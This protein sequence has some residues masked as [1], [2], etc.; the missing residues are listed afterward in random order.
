MW[1]HQNTQAVPESRILPEQELLDLLLVQSIG[2]DVGLLL[3]GDSRV[4][5]EARVNL[6]VQRKDTARWE[7]RQR[8]VS[9]WLC[10]P[11]RV[12]TAQL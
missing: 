3:V 4:S 2:G 8:E 9:I 6:E 12:F 7:S 10:S 11:M 1:I 5:E